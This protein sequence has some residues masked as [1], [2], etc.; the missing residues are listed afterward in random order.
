M[1]SFKIMGKWVGLFSI[2][3]FT[4]NFNVQAQQKPEI[5]WEAVPA[6][7][8]QI[9][10]P[11]FPQR[12][13]NVTDFGAKG[14]S[15][16]KCFD[17]FREAIDKCNQDGGGRVIVPPGKYLLNGPIHLKSNVNL[18]LSE[19]ARLEFSTNPDDFLPMVLTRWEGTE[20]YNYSP[21]IYAYQVTNVAIT[22]KGSIDGNASRSFAQW[23]PDQ[24][25]DQKLLRQMGNDGVPVYE[26][27]FGDGHKLRP[28]TIQFLGCKNVLVEGIS[29]YDAPFWV[30]HP[31]L[32]FNV[33]VRN[34]IVDSWNPNNDGVDPDASVNVLIEKS[35]FNC[36]DDAVAIKS[37]RDQDAWR[38]GQP[39]ENVII[40]GCIMNSK[41]NGLCIGSEMSGSV[42]NVFMEDCKVGEANSTIYFKGNLDRGGVVENIFVRNINVKRANTA[43]I[44]FDSN[45][46]GHRGNHFPPVFRWFT[47]ENV[48]CELAD[49]FGLFFKGVED[50]PVK[51]IVLK[52]I[53]I[54]KTERPFFTQ[55]VS[56]IELINVTANGVEIKEL[57]YYQDLPESEKELTW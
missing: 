2:F 39:T 54:L 23:K 21:F 24:K 5:G 6:I 38:I 10:V 1:I 8:N 37:G 35:E 15:L 3:V 18:H 51:N 53:N 30:I 20:L 26:R 42:R 33:T 52:N 7:I 29:I 41:A 16:T 13:Y 14:D 4:I 22:G 43:F 17:A 56:D 12:D 57:P 45:Y 46:K 44:R 47:I 40:R 32:C 9:I 19:G 34:V 28:G 50:M 36:G 31:A 49:D 11:V 55:Y 48:S 27:L 25:K